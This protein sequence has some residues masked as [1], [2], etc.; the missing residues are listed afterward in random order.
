MRKKKLKVKYPHGIYV[1]GTANDLTVV[2]F[3]STG[4]WYIAQPLDVLAWIPLS[5]QLFKL[6]LSDFGDLVPLGKLP[7]HKPEKK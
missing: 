6:L 5:I 2:K 3:D 4:M 7:H 1:T